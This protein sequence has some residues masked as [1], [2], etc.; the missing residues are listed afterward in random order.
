M[1]GFVLRNKAIIFLG[2]LFSILLIPTQVFAETAQT[3]QSEL[4]VIAQTDSDVSHSQNQQNY[5]SDELSAIFIPPPR[6]SQQVSTY[7]NY[8]YE[9][10]PPERGDRPQLRDIMKLTPAELPYFVTNY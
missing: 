6:T 3:K 2:L 1:M 5:S 7:T 9:T 10:P 4:S 8:R